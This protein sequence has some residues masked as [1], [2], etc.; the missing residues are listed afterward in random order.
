MMAIVRPV[1]VVFGMV[2]ALAAGCGGGS[3]GSGNF[4]EPIPTSLPAVQNKCP[5]AV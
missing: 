3:G 2:L 1:G 5:G 4:G